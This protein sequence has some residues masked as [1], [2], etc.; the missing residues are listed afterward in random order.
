M[1]YVIRLKFQ[2]RGSPHIHSFLWIANV[3]V[4]RENTIDPYT[5]WLDNITS[6]QLPDEKDDPVLLGLVKTYHLHKHSQTC[7]SI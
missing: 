2:V 3:V 5:K 6:A 7:K 4:L 1:Y